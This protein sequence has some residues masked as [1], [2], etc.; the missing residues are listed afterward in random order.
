MD[1]A[2]V[3]RRVAAGELQYALARFETIRRVF[4]FVMGL[5]RRP[6]PSWTVTLQQSMFLTALVDGAALDLKR[7]SFAG[8][9]DL[10]PA[11]VGELVDYAQAT[12]CHFWEKRFLKAEVKDGRLSDGTEVSMSEVCAPEACD[13]VRRLCRDPVLI[14]VAT[15]QLGYP[16]RRI[17]PRL[18]WSYAARIGDAVRRRQGQSID[19]HY[20]A[21]ALRFC[22]VNFYLTDV[23]RENGAHA[24]VRGSHRGK[25]LALLLRS[26]T[27]PD[28]AIRR[29]YGETRVTAIEGPAGTGFFEDTACYH[30]I[31]PPR[32]R[33]RL[34][35]EIWYS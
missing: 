32:R 30:R 11:V 24:L 29:H 34:M 4:G 2:S 23:D 17:R 6:G 27:V 21:H 12:P 16:P 5:F 15:R 20:D 14:A 26:A 19:W 7:D 25:P 3:A 8:G 31:I 10:P 28:E 9:F 33:D 1:V 35:L 22:S 13:A 18:Y